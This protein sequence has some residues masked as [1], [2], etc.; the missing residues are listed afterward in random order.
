MIWAEKSDLPIYRPSS[1]VEIKPSPDGFISSNTDA[2]ALRVHF[3][4][5]L[6]TCSGTVGKVAYVSRTLDG[7]IFSQDLF[8]INVF[9]DY[10]AGYLHTFLKSAVGQKFLSSL[11][12]GAVILHINPEH[13]AEIPIPDP[14]FELKRRIHDLIVRSYELRDESNDLLDEAERL[15]IA[16]LELPPIDRFQSKG[17][18]FSVKLSNIFASR[19]LDA[20]YHVPIVDRIV[21]HLKL[22]AAELTTVG[23]R[24]ISRKVILPGRFKRVYV[25]EGHGRVFIGGKQLGELDPS[26]KKYLSIAHHADRISAQL[27]LHENMTLITCSGTIGKVALVP[28]HWENWAASQHIIRVIPACEEIA[29]F[30]SVF[31]STDYGRELITRNTYGAV[32]DEITDYHVRAVPVPLLSDRSVQSRINALALEANERRFEAYQLERQALSIMNSEVLGLE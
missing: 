6:M 27:E 20:S 26:N 23:D 29:G 32:V 24:R 16:A 3:G 22:H 19:R 10:P 5:L 31:L 28:R 14:P 13:L 21:E 2:D 30:L 4:Q 7:K 15:L 8:R 11:T 1:S 18:G 17:M 25:D 12:Y 9:D